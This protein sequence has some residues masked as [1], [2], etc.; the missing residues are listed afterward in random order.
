VTRVRFNDGS[1]REVGEV[2]ALA[3]ATRCRDEILEYLAGRRREFSLAL[4]PEGTQFQ[5]EV[6]RALATIPFGDRRTY[7]QV[8]SQ[9]GRPRAA[10][11]VGLA[12]GANPLPLLIP[13]HRVVAENGGLGG[14]VAGTPHKRK[15]LELERWVAS[16]GDLV[17][18]P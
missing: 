13:C 6:W 14:F 17:L 12:C 1:G 3:I 2:P 11:A 8:A 18:A 4:D 7:G 10:R 5:L 16:E 9:V 15:L